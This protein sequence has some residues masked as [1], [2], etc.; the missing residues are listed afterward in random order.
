MSH[1]HKAAI[2]AVIVLVLATRT[3]TAVELKFGGM[4]GLAE[5]RLDMDGWGGSDWHTSVTVGGTASVVLNSALSIQTGV[6]YA[7]RSGEFTDQSSHPGGSLAFVDEASYRVDYL[8]TPILLRYR[9]APT[10]RRSP[11]LVAGPVLRWALSS[12]LDWQ[13]TEV[14]GWAN[15]ATIAL[16]LGLGLDTSLGGVL[17]SIDLLYSRSLGGIGDGTYY[18][19]DANFD[20]IEARLGIA[21]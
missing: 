6:A 17:G 15:T 9:L 7:R 5:S 18:T 2:L 13:G 12:E 3:A 19:D 16:A 1:L 21:F 10:A 11:V 8:E 14:E 20:G 4:V